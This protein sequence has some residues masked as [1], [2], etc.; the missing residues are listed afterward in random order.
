MKVDFREKLLSL[1][2]IPL[3]DGNEELTLGLV[4]INILLANLP[5]EKEIDGKE[6][7][8]RFKLAQK[9]DKADNKITINAEEVV[10]L[11]N[12]IGKAYSPL[13]VGRAYQILEGE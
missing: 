13:V 1:K 8:K 7:F 11:K 6:K 10:L 9:I 2:D 3:K 4:C 12:L 5:S